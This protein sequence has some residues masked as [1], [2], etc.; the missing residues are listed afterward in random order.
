MLNIPVI[1]DIDDLL[2]DRAYDKRQK[3]E[4]SHKYI[5]VI[6]ECD[7]VTVSTKFLLEKISD[8][9]SNAY[10]IRNTISKNFFLQSTAIYNSQRKNNE[11]ITLAY[12]SGSKTHDADFKIIEK[13]L[14][15][16]LEKFGFV[17]LLIVGF[18]N[19]DHSKFEKFNT[20]IEHRDKIK[21]SNYHNIF[22]E[23]DI[24]LVPL[25]LN[26]FCHAKSELKYIEAGACGIPSVLTPT[27]SHEDI[28]INGE[29]GLLCYDHNDWI[30]NLSLLIEN[31]TLRDKI[32]KA[33]R[34]DIENNYTSKA[35]A[36]DWSLILKKI[37][38][39]KNNKHSAS[40]FKLLPHQIR[41][42]IMILYRRVKMIN[43]KIVKKLSN[44]KF[45]KIIRS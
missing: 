10:L 21:Y 14:V 31:D 30:N 29:N 39:E 32:G 18:L 7:A 28:I 19:Y 25:E 40:F 26:D 4:V 35:R 2:F 36:N 8:Y 15:N 45:S 11:T 38:E 41:L 33:A 24:N 9:N 5:A 34:I 3:K 20:R 44:V 27:K 22:R 43:T 6:K 13:I 37:S 42:K 16:I 17:K 12:L 23:I 1:Y